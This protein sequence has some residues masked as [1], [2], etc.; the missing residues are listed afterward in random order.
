MSFEYLGQK[1]NADIDAAEQLK[2]YLIQNGGIEDKNI[3]SEHEAWRVKFSDATFTYYKKGTLFST[4]TNDQAVKDAWDFVATLI[5]STLIAPTRDFCIG[6][7]ETGKGEVLGHTVLVGVIFPA[8]IFNEV[9][10]LVGVADT[11]KKH[12]VDY[13][14][15]ILK[16]MDMMRPKGL[17]FMVEKIPPWH[18][19]KF[20][21]NKFMDVVYQRILSN[22]TRHVELSKC[23]IV[24]DDYG[25]GES[26]KRFLR[27]LENAGAEVKVVNKADVI[28]LESKVASV[29]AKREREKVIE[30]ISRSG[31]FKLENCSIGSGNAGDV[32]TLTWLKAWKQT[33]KSW[34]WFVKRSFKTVCEIDGRS[35]VHKSVIPLRAD[36]LS[37]DFIEQFEAGQFSIT[38]LSI[39][40]PS[41]GERSKAA[42]V[43]IDN[44]ETCIRCLSCKKSIPDINTTLRYYC[45]F[46]LPD[47]NIILGGL[48]SKDLELSKFFE[49]FTVLFNPVVKKEC[50]TSGG[51]REFDK[52]ANFAAMGRIRLDEITSASFDQT[53]SSLERD[54][55]IKNS[56]LSSNA[57][58]MTGDGSM[59][60]F[61]QAQNLFCLHA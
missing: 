24:L 15:D 43:T 10:E 3:K 58:L 38:S 60:A 35:Q 20:N 26:L 57:I 6:F 4:G 16:R 8:K 61:A 45:G 36:I 25:V 46:L 18:V 23:R 41:C 54:E 44:K 40:C 13:W 9:K 42:L 32:N 33:G 28:Y 55:I 29:L 37:K 2:G 17:N 53:S 12:G 1:W 19:D 22:F 11:K 21:L 39:V 34:P 51:K 14:D 31:E 7:D 52:L 5:D 27:S 30:A 59:K 48:L 56:A 50:D 49:G 47:S